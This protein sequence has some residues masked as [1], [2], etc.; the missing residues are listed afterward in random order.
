MSLEVVNAK[1]TDVEPVPLLILSIN[2]RPRRRAQDLH[3]IVTCAQKKRA[4]YVNDK[5]DYATE[6]THAPRIIGERLRETVL[7]SPSFSCR[8]N[9]HNDV[10]A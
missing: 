10:E 3:G 6:S 5:V 7:E 4:E 2:L 9:Q 1:D 8:N